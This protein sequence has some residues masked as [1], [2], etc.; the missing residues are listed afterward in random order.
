MAAQF[1][2]NN[3]GVVVIIGSGAGGGTLG[4]ELA[5]KGIDVIILEAGARHEYE[6]FTN[7]EWES[8]AQFAWK[9]KRTTS[10]DW[11]VAKDFPNLP[12][13]I[14]K[15]VGGSTTH[16][17]G[18]SLRFQEHEFKAATTY[19]KVK[20]ANLLDWPVTLAEME[21]YYAKAEA[22][23]GVTGTNNWPR[24]PGNNNFKV[25]KAGADKLGYKECHTG[26]MAINSV[27]RDDRNSC[28]QTGFCFQGCKWG[29]KW[30]TLY[31]EIP[32]GEATG[33]LE[34]RP[35]SMAIKINHDASGKVTGVVYADKDGKLQEQKA[36]IV[37]VA[38]N[39]IES[40]RLLLNSESSKFPHGLANSSGQVG[41]NYMRHTTGSV[42]AIFDKPV[43]MYRGT[44]MA[45]IIRDEARHDP[46]RG[47]V[48]GYE[49]ETLSLGL[50]FMAAFLNPGGWGR[51]FTT[52]LDHYDHMAGLWI[53]G[54]DMPREENRITLHKD[55]KDEHGMPIA[56]V[57]FDDHPNDE[58][59]RN[60][61]YSQGQ[62]L[63]AAV[64][65][66]RTF[67]TPPY[68]S[69]HNL[70]TNRMS[71]KPEDGVV[72]KH[73]QSHDIKNLFISDGSQ[74]T[75]GAAE[76]PTLT[77][78]TLAIRQADYIAAQMSAKTI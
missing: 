46:S 43:H 8:F 30:S 76:N 45:G 38:G 55:E 65:A 2:L 23:M 11:R 73:G 47:F 64:G 78:V 75:T 51:S 15:S 34:V 74:F 33:H 9:D 77:I 27:E 10:G 71:E 56:D 54:E 42:Y 12:A 44:T 36:R 32:K 60:H 19:G 61:A 62:A 52:A 69:T 20:G 5:Q 3:D 28:Q 70:G 14:V 41:K 29:A 24:L 16:W 35:N 49:M 1:D 4:N 18:A 68:P 57:H 53:V 40:P 13:W 63:Y 67:P 58:A 25:L 37:A 31:T 48:G 6:D 50:P 39:S 66:T 59:M 72:N 26:N 21:P 17:A 7:D 22:K